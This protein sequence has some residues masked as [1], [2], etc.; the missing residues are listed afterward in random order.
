[1][2]VRIDTVLLAPLER[3]AAEVLRPRL[4]E[5]I[6][7]PLVH[8]TPLEP[9]RF[10]EHWAEGRWRV[11]IRLFG[12]FPLGRQWIVITLPATGTGEFRVR[13]NGTGDLARRWDH[14][15]ILQRRAD[16]STNYRDEVTVAAGL[17]TPFVW[18]FAALFYRHRQRRWRRLVALDFAY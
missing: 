4:L 18:A 12:V 15:I 13:D 2:L 10:P 6:A 9:A 7:A 17:L 8:F 11:A 16:G 5:Y 14:L 3:I 1:M